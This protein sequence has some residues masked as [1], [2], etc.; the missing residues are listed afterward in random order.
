MKK[1]RNIP[2]PKISIKESVLLEIF[3]DTNFTN[4]IISS[5]VTILKHK[6]K[7]SRKQPRHQKKQSALDISCITVFDLDS[8]IANFAPKFNDNPTT[9]LTK[10]NQSSASSVTTMCISNQTSPTGPGASPPDNRMVDDDDDNDNNDKNNNDEEPN[11]EYTDN[12]AVDLS[13]AHTF[14]FLI[15]FNKNLLR[16][17]QNIRPYELA[18]EVYSQINHRTQIYCIHLTN[19]YTFPPPQCIYHERDL[20]N[21][22]YDFTKFHLYVPG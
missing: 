6:K 7:K 18:H 12:A 9:I 14:K 8:K 2:N 1:G 21:N 15:K 22:D 13:G 4:K 5:P 19:N 16:R 11:P 3:R 17:R 20:P 10:N